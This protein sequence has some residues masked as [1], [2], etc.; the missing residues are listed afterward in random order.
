MADTAPMI[1][2]RSEFIH[3]FEDRMSL[4]MSTCIKEGNV[5][6]NQITF[7][8]ATSGGASAVTRGING[9]IP[10]RA[11]S[12]VQTAAQLIEYHDLVRKTEFNILIS[13]GDQRRMMQETG[14]AVINRRVDDSIITALDTGTNNTGAAAV[15]SLDLVIWAQT[16]LGNNQV[17]ITDEDNLF[18]VVSPAFHGYMLQTT[19]FASADFVEVKPLTGPAR[20]YRRFA[21][22]NWIVHGRLTNSVGAGGSGSSEQCFFFHRNAIGCGVHKEGISTS[23]GFDDEQA[24]SFARHTV[25]IGTA[26]LQD[27]GL[28]VA[29]HD[30]SGYAAT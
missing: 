17:D 29:L 21:G 1:A 11:D 14:M 23:I 3:G 10:A 19:E 2:Y 28:V 12:Q 26:L 22:F 25:H 6:G 13:Q 18:A 15:A 5:N 9:M 27:S 24:Y 20:R 16:I 30:G 7:N 8:V 4:L